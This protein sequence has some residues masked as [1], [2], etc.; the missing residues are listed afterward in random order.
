MNGL[1]LRSR[2]VITLTGRHKTEFDHAALVTAA[3]EGYCHAVAV[4]SDYLRWMLDKNKPVHA[5]LNDPTRLW[6]I[7]GDPEGHLN[8]R[9]AI[10][11]S[12]LSLD[13]GASTI[14]S[15]LSQARFKERYGGA[16]VW[17]RGM[18]VVSALHNRQI[19]DQASGE[20]IPF[21]MPIES[22]TS[23]GHVVIQAAFEHLSH[24]VNL[25]GVFFQAT[26]ELIAWSRWCRRRS[27]PTDQASI[28]VAR[29][30][31]PTLPRDRWWH[32]IEQIYVNTRNEDTGPRLII[33]CDNMDDLEHGLDLCGDNTFGIMEW[34]NFSLM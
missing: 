2:I 21:Q 7:C 30:F 20:L 14:I 29:R 1:D 11:L 24:S 4:Q 13:D 15:P 25:E 16:C 27:I 9:A 5:S 31:H 28:L 34:D 6:C 8:T 22:D 18:N 10:I 17:E 33:P 12:A 3:N 19:I 23:N 26:A 32:Y